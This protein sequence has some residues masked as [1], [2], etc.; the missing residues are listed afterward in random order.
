MKTTILVLITCLSL[1]SVA[2]AQTPALSD[3]FAAGKL[4]TSTWFAQHGDAPD[5]KHGNRWG[6]FEPEQL[7]FSQGMLRLGISQTNQNGIITS[8]SSEIITNGLYGYGTYTFVMRM[9]STSPTHDSAGQTKSGGCSAAFLFWGNSDTEIDIEYLGDK[10]NSLYFTTWQGRSRK[11][12]I[13]KSVGNISQGMHKFDIVWKP[14]I[15]QWYL[16]G[17]LVATSTKFVPSHPAQIRI[18]HWGTHNPGWGGF[19]TLNVNRYMY[20][21]SVSFTPWNGR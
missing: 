17:K 5:N 10:P 2:S 11:N 21:K 3:N 14:G 7:D 15:V 13:V 16:D 4:D 9:A 1:L 20:V 18:N 12:T 6:A 19:A 8:R